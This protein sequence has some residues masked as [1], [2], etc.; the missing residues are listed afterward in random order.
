MKLNFWQ[1]LGVVLLVI[2]AILW[3]MRQRNEAKEKE[4]GTPQIQFSPEAE[5]PTTEP[6]SAPATAPAA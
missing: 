1:W 4:F 5:E 3:F 6:T 2:A